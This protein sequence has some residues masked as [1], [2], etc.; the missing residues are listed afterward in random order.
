MAD[1]RFYEGLGPVAAETLAAGLSV[2]GQS[3]TPVMTAAVFGAG[4]P[5]ALSYTD[6]KAGAAF[7]AVQGC[8][9]ARE[10][11][12]TALL[13]A[14]AAAVIVSPTPRA[15]F[16]RL[17]N[18][19]YR[20]RSWSDAGDPPT[21]EP[22]ARIAPT[23]VV[24]PGCFIGAGAE[25]APFAV[26]G[27]GC[28]I[29]RGTSIGPHTTAQCALIGDGVTIGAGT[30]VG[31]RGFGVT[32]DAGGLIDIPHLGRV[33]LQ[34][35]VSL[36]ANCTVDRGMLDDTVIGEDSKIDN[37]SQIAHNV[38]IGRRVVVAAFGG[39]SGSTIVGDGVQMGG[40]V[41]IADHRVMGDGSSLAAGSAV[42]H[43]V[44]AGETWG[45]Y[46]AQPVRQWMK[47]TAWLRRALRKGDGR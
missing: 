20:L 15:T 11:N 14:G 17:I 19:I 32:G 30:I 10:A 40:R 43:D 5:D 9:I 7:T 8:V 6:S 18:R 46:P 38:R 35:R 22:G 26:I 2:W 39:I 23:A 16:A 36:G 28:T 29:G 21:I 41:G 4:G 24:S 12:A 37:L 33:I 47:E 13:E 34:D 45:G 42:M 1:K 44:P 3:Q 27:P 31:E 25:I